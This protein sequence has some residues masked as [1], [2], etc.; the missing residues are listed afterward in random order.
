VAST[1]CCAD[2]SALAWGR[3][4]QESWASP[5]PQPMVDRCTEWVSERLEAAEFMDKDVIVLL[6]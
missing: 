1:H 3:L 5:L 4:E 6:A 2:I